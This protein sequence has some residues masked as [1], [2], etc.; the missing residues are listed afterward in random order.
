M[1][2]L[3]SIGIALILTTI[4]LSGCNTVQGFGKDLQQGGQSL[5][6]AAKDNK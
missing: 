4:F 5:Q 2:K 3:S 6:Q 1:K